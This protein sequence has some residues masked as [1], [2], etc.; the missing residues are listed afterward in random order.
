M[1]DFVALFLWTVGVTVFF[2]LLY[3]I[4]KILEKIEIRRRDNFYR[5]FDEKVQRMCWES[6]Y[7]VPYDLSKIEDIEYEDVTNQKCISKLS[8]DNRQHNQPDGDAVAER[9]LKGL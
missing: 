7:G 3:V 2:T 8:Y 9:S 6:F 1:T 4:Y 5:D